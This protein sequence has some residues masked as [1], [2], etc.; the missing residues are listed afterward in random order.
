MVHTMNEKEP[1]PETRLVDY[2]SGKLRQ[3]ISDVHD[4]C[5]ERLF[6]EARMFNLPPSEL[7]CLTLF[8]GNRYLTGIEIAAK[9][10]IAKSRATVILDSLSSRGLIQ[11]NPDPYDARIKL[12]S[13]TAAGS[14]KIQEIEDFIFHLYRQLLTQIEP[15]QRPGII[16]ALEVLT[17]SMKAMKAQMKANL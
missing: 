11:R 16:A 15:A 5:R 17:S 1:T 14:K 12:V 9:L 8:Q 3:L 4:C 2:Q 13:L 10:E 7:K 6:L